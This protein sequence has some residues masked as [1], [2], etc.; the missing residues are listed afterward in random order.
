MNEF[1]LKQHVF[2]RARTYQFDIHYIYQTLDFCFITKNLTNKMLNCRIRIDIKQNSNYYSISINLNFTIVDVETRKLYRWKNAIFANIR[3]KFNEL[4]DDL[5]IKQ[6][7]FLTKI[8]EIIDQLIRVIDQIIIARVL[9][10]NITRNSKSNFF[11]KCKKICAKIQRRK[12]F[13]QFMIV[14][15]MLEY[16]IEIAK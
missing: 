16:L 6:L 10:T 15:F 12:R 1:D 5:N 2:K 9:K 4:I 8:D 3:N 11:K 7:N 13:F 14:A